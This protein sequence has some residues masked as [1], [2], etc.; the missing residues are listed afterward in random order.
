MAIPTLNAVGFC[1]HYS[2]QGDWA[3]DY[4][5]KLSRIHSLQLNVFHFLSDPY[6]GGDD[7][8]EKLWPDERARL[9]IQKEKELRMYYDDRAGD[10]LDVGF[11]L[12]EHAEWVE[13]HRCLVVREFQV[14]VLGYIRHGIKFGVHSI[15]EFA[16]S[17]ISPVVLV[18]PKKSD[19]VYLNSRAMLIKDQ[20]ALEDTHWKPLGDIVRP[21]KTGA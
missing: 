10:Y 3:F 8:A 9:A 1:A 12:C 13:L 4:A 14:L 19:Q 16:E 21:T 18:G 11:R 7:E 17:F 15:E 2:D 5:L 6:A 20:L